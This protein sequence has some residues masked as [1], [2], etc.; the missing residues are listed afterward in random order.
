M[1]NPDQY[2][3]VPKSLD[4]G[5]ILMGFPRVEILPALMIAGTS[6]MIHHQMIGLSVASVTFFSIK[7][8]RR[9]YGENV[10]S[11]IMYSYLS[12]NKSN[13]FFKRLPSSSIKYWRY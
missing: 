8:V 11:R 12:T 2:Y 4:K 5:A 9:R 13:N 3:V 6:F 1:E 10:F 7:Y